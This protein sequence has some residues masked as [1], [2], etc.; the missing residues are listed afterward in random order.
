[1]R[2]RGDC[3]KKKYLV[4]KCAYVFVMVFLFLIGHRTVEVSPIMKTLLEA[5]ERKNSI[6]DT[7][8]IEMILEGTDVPLEPE[9]I[10]VTIDYAEDLEL[11][12]DSEL[13]NWKV[14]EYEE[15]PQGKE[16][17][18]RLAEETAKALFG[19]YFSK[20]TRQNTDDYMLDYSDKEKSFHFYFNL[21]RLSRMSFK[22]F[23]AEPEIEEPEDGD[24][25]RAYQEYSRELF[26]KLKLGSWDGEQANLELEASVGGTYVYRYALDGKKITDVHFSADIPIYI[27]TITLHYNK[28][29]LTEIETPNAFLFIKNVRDAKVKYS[30]IEKAMEDVEEKLRA[31]A[32]NNKFN[33]QYTYYR[34]D[35]VRLSYMNRMTGQFKEE[36]SLMPILDIGMTSCSYSIKERSWNINP[37]RHYGIMLESG[38]EHWG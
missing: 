37:S 31:G 27:D 23:S 20:A 28:G 38:E 25:D 5:E 35:S 30:S 32:L 10:G 36:Y 26:Q 33:P 12:E 22:H 19:D 11:P 3:L 18:E 2:E 4:I 6:K 16:D 9:G 14:Y 8:E 13:E 29:V 24:W 15:L 21:T 1:L 17:K 7:S 34:I